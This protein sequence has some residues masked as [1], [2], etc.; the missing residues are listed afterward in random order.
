MRAQSG[1]FPG[2]AFNIGHED[3]RIYDKLNYFG[4]PPADVDSVNV[5]RSNWKLAENKL[6]SA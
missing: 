1:L 4:I 5:L 6:F 3:F 2:P